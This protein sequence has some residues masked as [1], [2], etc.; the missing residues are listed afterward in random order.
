[1]IRVLTVLAQV[2]IVLSSTWAAPHDLT[3]SSRA[4]CTLSLTRVG[5]M[6]VFTTQTFC[7]SIIARR[8]GLSD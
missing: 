1:M 5:V 7:S 8:R 6:L 3:E 4:Q 2:D